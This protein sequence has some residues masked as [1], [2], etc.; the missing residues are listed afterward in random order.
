MQKAAR[1]VCARRRNS[2]TT[3]HLKSHPRNQV[4]AQKSIGAKAVAVHYAPRRWC[5][6]NEAQFC[7]RGKWEREREF[8][9][10]D[11][12]QSDPDLLIVYRTLEEKEVAEVC[13]SVASDRYCCCLL[14]QLH[15][16]CCGQ[17]NGPFLFEAAS[18]MAERPIT[19]GTFLH[20][21]FL[22]LSTVTFRKAQH[23]FSDDMVRVGLNWRRK[24]CWSS[25]IDGGSNRRSLRT[26]LGGLD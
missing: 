26:C 17:D 9:V 22:Q 8:A 24:Y 1:L 7:R 18:S 10:T 13:F 25:T 12:I 20:L 14:L 5:D 6:Q 15:S 23:R 19:S 2:S 16:G 11:R 3:R 4:C 21:I